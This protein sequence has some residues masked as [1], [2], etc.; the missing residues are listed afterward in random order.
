MKTLK[1]ILLL[2]L[3][4]SAT[5]LSAQTDQA[6]LTRIITAQNFV[7]AANSA[8]PLNSADIDRVM[9]KMPGYTGGG[10]INLSTSNYTLSVT[11]DSLVAYLPYFGRSYTPKMGD[12]SDSGI[13]FTSKDFK[14][15]STQTKKGGWTITM[16]PNDVR[17][18]YNLTLS[19]TK[20]G[21][22]TLTVTSN[23]QQAITFNGNINE[24]K[25][26]KTQ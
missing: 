25:I 7:F 4:F 3:L 22:A 20:S 13:K 24:P 14:Y 11:P 26:K 21:Y 1:N 19:I 15:K 6:T 8:N 5:R 17:D 23:S 12:P 10:N 16:N 18:N 9:R 2:V